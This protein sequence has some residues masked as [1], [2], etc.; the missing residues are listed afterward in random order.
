VRDGLVET[1]D[2]CRALGT[3]T[4]DAHVAPEH[5]QELRQFVDAHLSKRAPD[6]PSATLDLTAL[7]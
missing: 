6:A 4:D 5:V 3:W 1:L 7:P 2:E